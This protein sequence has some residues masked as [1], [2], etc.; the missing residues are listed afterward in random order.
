MLSNINLVVFE[1]LIFYLLHLCQSKSLNTNKLK[2]FLN[3]LP[4]YKESRLNNTP[5]NLKTKII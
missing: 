3:I 5:I 1:L 4:N 2:I